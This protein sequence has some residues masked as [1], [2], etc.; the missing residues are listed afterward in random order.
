MSPLKLLLAEI[1]YRKL[2]FTL[3]LLAVVAAATLFVAGPVLIDG[4]GQET[5]LR[6]A[7]IQE[8]TD[9]SAAALDGRLAEIQADTESKTRAVDALL[10]QMEDETRK[11][12]LTM[13]FNLMIVHRDTN[14]ADF[15]ADDFASHDLPQAYVDQLADSPKLEHVR[16]LVATLQKKIEW[17]KRRVLL[18]GYLAETPQKHFGG[19]KE[20]SLG[21]NIKPGEAYLGYELWRSFDLKVGDKIDIAGQ[22]FVVA[23]TQKERGGKQDIELSL[24]LADAQRVLGAPGRVSQIMALGCQCEGERLPTIRNE[25]AEV[26]PDTKISEFD[27]IAQAR[28]EQRQLV[29]DQRQE[30]ARQGE[31]ERQRLAGQRA[32]IVREGEERRQFVAAKRVEVQ[33]VLENLAGAVTPLVVLVCALWIGLLA[34][35]NVRERRVEIG[36]LRALGKSSP[37]I[38]A[39]FLGRA[40]VLGLLG[41]GLGYLLAGLVAS[42]VTGMVQELGGSPISFAPPRELL[43]WTMLGAP[44]VCALACYL[45][46]LRAI[47]QDP[48]SVLREA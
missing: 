43:L 6:L 25:L 15:W 46:T 1:R 13:G 37:Y 16:H 23:R 11:L 17:R 19:K 21:P 45:P 41:G 12:M 30:I 10:A 34:W 42:Q 27:S 39:L 29:A 24:N 44:L 26:L 47:T 32:A 7:A 8:E 14:M 5:R 28:A 31:E 48:A 22:S 40:I 3:S 4:Y 2:N 36:V 38:A 18:V 9:R 33:N 35:A 20:K